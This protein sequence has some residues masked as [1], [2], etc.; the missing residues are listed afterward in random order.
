MG[1]PK[2]RSGDP[3]HVF[4]NAPFDDAYLPLLH[5]LLFTVHACGFV[6]RTA[7]EDVG[8]AEQRLHKIVR[9]IEQTRY[10]IHDLSRVKLEPASG[11][12]RFNMPFELGLAVGAA[13][14]GGGEGR[15]FLVMCGAAH[16]DKA[17][18]SDM[19]GQDAKAHDDEPRKLVDC[20]RNFL[21]AKKGWGS[22]ALG[23]KEIWNRFESF[24]AQ[25]P[26]MAVRARLDSS[27]LNTFE[28]LNEWLYLVTRWLPDATPTVIET[29]SPSA[30]RHPAM[31]TSGSGIRRPRR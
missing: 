3:N 31:K 13:R 25:L 19:A 24:K 16:Q 29:S 1:G 7:L 8:G 10:S 12:P 18:L 23:G 22:G 21:I 20:V 5:S 4:V 17:A 2:S 27:E 6:A 9:I 30:A 11:L 28:Y 26:A 15:D 14:F